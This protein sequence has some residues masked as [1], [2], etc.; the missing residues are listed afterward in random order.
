MVGLTEDQLYKLVWQ[1]LMWLLGAFGVVASATWWAKGQ[2]ETSKIN[3]LQAEI[4][5]ADNLAKHKSHTTEAEKR[6]LVAR[7]ELSEQ[8]LKHQIDNLKGLNEIAEQRRQYAEDRLKVSTAELQQIKAELA[9]LKTATAS[10]SS[11]ADDVELGS[12]RL[13]RRDGTQKHSVEDMIK[14]L[15]MSIDTALS[16]NNQTGTILGK[17]AWSKP[18]ELNEVFI[19]PS[20]GQKE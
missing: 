6:E 12:G 17:E 2:L 8:G 19:Y 5:N 13:P 15:E 3:G 7:N 14:A 1:L 9:E 10:G 4:K 20:I 18:I 16:A 11:P